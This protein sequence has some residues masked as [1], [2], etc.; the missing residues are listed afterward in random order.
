MKLNVLHLHASDHCRWAVESKLFPQ[1]TEALR[2]SFAGYYT[3]ADIRDLVSYANARGVRLVPEFDLPAHARG[4]LPLASNSSGNLV[5][6]CQKQDAGYQRRDQLY[7]STTTRATL[8]KL[9]TE[10]ASLFNDNVIHIGGDETYTAGPCNRTT[11]RSLQQFLCGV[12]GRLNK[13]VAGWEEL[14][15]DAGAASPH[16]IIQAWGGFVPPNITGR[17]RY[18]LNSV[19][20]HLYT[21]NEVG[22]GHPGAPWIGW[23]RA[24]YD[25]AAGVPQD[26]RRMLLGGEMALWTDAYCPTLQCGAFGGPPQPSRAM[27]PPQQDNAFGK[28][29]GGILWPFGY[30]GAGSFWNY[31]AGLDP[32]TAEFVSRIWALNDKLQQ[33]GSIVCPSRCNCTELTACGKPYISG[34]F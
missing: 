13:S 25:I 31:D 32:T 30:I 19:S 22:P 21:G 28:S 23:A 14:L 7:G 4:L 5:Q 18:A 33:R 10:M 6:F 11:T 9:L 16:A 24:H 26:Q 27:F 34:N 1:L 15:F 29:V 20:H 3:Q 8:E 2:G 17:G 12:V